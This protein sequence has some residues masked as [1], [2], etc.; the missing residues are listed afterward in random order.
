METKPIAIDACTRCGA[1][2]RAGGPALHRQDRH[3]VETGLIHT[4]DLY[5][6]RR[7]EMA[8]DQIRSAVVPVRRDIIKIKGKGGT[9]ACRFFDPAAGSCRIYAERPL[10]C[11]L[12][13][14]WNTGRIARA[15]ARGRLTRRDL[16]GEL[17]GVWAVVEEHQ[18]RCDYGLIRKLLAPAPAQSAERRLRE[19]TAIIRYD[20]QL[21]ERVLARIGLEAQML[22][23]LFGR[24]L[25][26]TLPL[27]KASRDPAGKPPGA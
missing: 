24:P 13:E 18:R 2:C 6:I 15:Y 22:D 17:Q 20:E 21:R 9:W 3:L 25:R 23:F 1:C 5:T 19:L 8:H 4:R 11:R 14:C 27:L 10:E 7:G 26:R 16:I 12:L